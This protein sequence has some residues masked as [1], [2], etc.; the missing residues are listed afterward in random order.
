MED[1][2]LRAFCLV[3][4]MKSFSKAAEAKFMTQSAMSHLIKGLEDELEV[5]L[6]TRDAKA[7]EP[8]PAGRLF[9]ENA[10]QIL[11]N[12]RR[13]EDEICSFTK[14][15]KGPLLIGASP[16]AAN[17][18]LPQVLYDFSKDHPTVRIE[19]SIAGSEKTVDDLSEG[20]IAL[21]IIDS[22]IKNARIFAEEIID[23]EIVII[24]SDD[25]PLTKKKK[26]SPAELVSQPIILPDID[27]GSREFINGFLRGIGV[28]PERIKVSMI[29]GSPELIIQMVRAGQGI[30][31]ISKWAAFSAIKDGT[32]SMLKISEEKLTRKFSMITM[33]KEPSNLTARTFRDFIRAYR[34]FIPF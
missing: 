21:G 13:L 10:K 23:D 17:Y 27:A 14:N 20:R 4:E 19:L 28:S 11:V 9:Y 3:V 6:L 32:I 25:N 34:F 16:T 5:K 1:H 22:S 24:A 33:D 2:R 31:F 29:L 8:T 12:Y 26:L 7:I 18:L 15:I 30:S